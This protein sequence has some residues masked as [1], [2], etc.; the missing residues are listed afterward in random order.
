VKQDCLLIEGR[1]PASVC[2][3]YLVMLVWPFCCCDLDLYPM[4]LICDTDVD[5]LKM[6]LCTK[7]KLLSNGF[8][9]SQANRTDTHR[10][11]QTWPNALL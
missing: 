9:K 2:D 11:R 6:Y 7:M 5:V 8:H 4:T 3:V 1:P 10:D